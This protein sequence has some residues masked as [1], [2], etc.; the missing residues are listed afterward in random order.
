MPDILLREVRRMPDQ[1]DIVTDKE[2]AE[3][4]RSMIRHE[5]S[6][7]NRRLYWCVTIEGLLMASL[8]FAWERRRLITGPRYLLPTFPAHLTSCLQGNSWRVSGSYC[9]VWHVHRCLQRRR[10]FHWPWA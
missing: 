3:I 7:L 4:T 1:P 10:L 8:S 6:V 9:V 2:Y 5:D